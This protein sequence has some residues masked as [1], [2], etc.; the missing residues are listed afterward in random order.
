M[1]RARHFKRLAH[2]A[3]RLP[4]LGRR[5]GRKL[6]ILLL[7]G[8]FDDGDDGL[9]CDDGV[10][11]RDGGGGGRDDL[12]GF[13]GEDGVVSDILDDLESRLAVD[14]RDALAE[15]E[16]QVAERRTFS[17]CCLSF[18]TPDSRQ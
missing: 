4:I 7:D 2:S 8:T 1:N 6:P 3:R 17:I 16:T 15:A 10:G 9:G 5:C 14:L 11:F 12:D 13:F 18:R